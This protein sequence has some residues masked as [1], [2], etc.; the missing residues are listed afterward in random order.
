MFSHKQYFR[1]ILMDLLLLRLLKIHTGKKPR[2]NSS[3]EEF[4]K[5]KSWLLLIIVLT[6]K[7]A[8]TCSELTIEI[9]EQGVK[10]VQS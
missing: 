1:E 7:L 6:T 2:N 10:Y 3:V 8:F 4:L 9:L 5:M